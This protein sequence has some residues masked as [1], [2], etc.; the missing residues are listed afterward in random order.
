MNDISLRTA[1]P[2]DLPVLLEFEQNIIRTERPYNETLR[3]D[4]IRYYDIEAM[5]G[6]TNTEVIVG[7]HDQVIV[8]SAYATIREAKSY[9]S[10]EKFVYLGFMFVRPSYRGRGING[11]I[12]DAIKSWSLSR[13]ISELRLDVYDQ[14]SSAIRAYEKAGFKKHLINMKLSI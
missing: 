7:I 6:D 5:L 2:E 1:R 10:H 9:L 12:I 14:N 8:A 13:N 11:T 3:P 4:P